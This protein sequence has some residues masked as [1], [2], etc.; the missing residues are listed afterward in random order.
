MSLLSPIHHTFA[1]LADGRQVRLTL[2]LLFRPWKWKNGPAK[3]ELRKELGTIFRGNAFL[4]ASGR[5][6]LFALFKALRCQKNEEIIVQGY[7][8]VVVPNAIKAAG[9]APVFVDID[10]DTLSL[11][12]QETERAI[13]PK[14]R[15]ILCQHTFGIPALTKELRA[16]CDRHGLVLM[17]DCAHI[18]PDR[19]EPK[20]VGRFGDVFLLSFGR[21]KAIS[22]VT[23]GAVVVKQKDT[24]A[25]LQKLEKDAEKL[26]LLTI[27]LLL[28]YPLLY[29]LARPFY[30]IGIGKA[31][32][33][34]CGKLHI[35]VPILR[36]RE[37]Q[38]EMSPRL[39]AL[40]N[41]CAALALEQLRRIAAL[42]DHR[43]ALTKLYF[44]EGTKR[45]WKMLLGVTPFLPLQKFPLFTKHAEKIRRTLKKDNIHLHDGWT[46]CVICPASVDPQNLGYRD[47]QDP[48]AEMAGEQILS[49]PTHPTMTKK[50]AQKLVALLDPLLP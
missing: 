27:K 26:S 15:A 24:A 34:L 14:T 8:C 44:E 28:L 10:P 46:G 42:N 29:G 18:I 7:T 43:R 20:E 23:G 48:D 47:G 2:S 30:G 4:F 37:K 33:A 9:M 17:E 35:L 12:L 19:G 5:E 45:R 50:Q 32:L 1:P 25:S 38:G 40:P 11:D 6:A 31:F 36:S 21:D 3:E 16:L 39:H 41:A 22:G 13:T 49:L